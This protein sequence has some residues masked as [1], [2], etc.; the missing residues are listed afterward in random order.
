MKKSIW[1]KVVQGKPFTGSPDEKSC[2]FC[3]T[4]SEFYGTN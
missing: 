1:L 3:G 2:T 4:N